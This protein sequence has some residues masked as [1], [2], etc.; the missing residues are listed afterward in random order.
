MA[1]GVGIAYFS[2]SGSWFGPQ[3]VTI[4]AM[5]VPLY[6]LFSVYDNAHSS[7]MALDVFSGIRRAVLALVATF[8][9]MLLISFLLQSTDQFSRI[10]FVFGSALA[11]LFVVLG[12]TLVGRVATTFLGRHPYAVLRIFDGVE[13]G[14]VEADSV[15]R[16]EEMGLVPDPGNP[17]MTKALGDVTRGMDRVIVYCQVKDRVNWATMLRSLDIPSELVMTEL[18]DL[19]PLAVFR[20]ENDVALQLSSGTLPWNDRLIKRTFDLAV[21][22]LASPFLAPV[23]AVI[24]IAIKLDSP[25]PVFFTQP[26]IG[27]GNRHFNIIK[28]RSMKREMSDHNGTRSTDRDDDR[29]T[30]VG[31]FIRRTSLDEL[32]QVINVLMGDMSIV[33][34][35]PHAQ[36]S[37]AENLLFWDIDRR[38]WH[39]H[40][41]KPG[42]T[43]LAQVRGYR[44]ATHSKSD[45]SNRLHSDLEYVANWSLWSDIRI[46][47]LTFGVIFHRNAF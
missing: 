42:L 35:R 6:F 43:G 1:L 26:R 4:L 13:I 47:F 21:V 7:R 22:L 23:F 39:R 10:V 31:R 14:D 34:P 20:R 24:A 3:L 5:M 30:R 36:G 40:A 46:V 2:R 11:A 19:A 29:V 28:F 33:G 12:R 9:S 25:G 27:L 8:G 37:R 15:L 32:P 18:N 38:Y 44:G 17:A 45:L 16:A 41:V